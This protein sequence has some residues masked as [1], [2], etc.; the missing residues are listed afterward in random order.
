MT[1]SGQKMSSIIDS[2]LLFATL[3][4][5]EVVS[6]PLDMPSI[7]SEALNKPWEHR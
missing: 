4:K 6:T 2:L 5:E 3:R 7:V 1:N